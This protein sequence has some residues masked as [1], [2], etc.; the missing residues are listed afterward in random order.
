MNQL[1]IFVHDNGRIL[2]INQAS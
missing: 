1:Q 2:M